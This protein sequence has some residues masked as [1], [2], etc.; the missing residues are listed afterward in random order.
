MPGKITIN[1]QEYDV[2]QLPLEVRQRLQMLQFVD[3]ELQRLA[4]QTAAMETAKTAYTNSLRAEMQKLQAPP[5]VDPLLAGD[6]IKL[7]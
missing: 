7:G 6:T 3:G 5:A 1:Q 4:A 2:D